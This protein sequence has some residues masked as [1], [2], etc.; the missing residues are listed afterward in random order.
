[1]VKIGY[2]SPVDPGIDRMAWSGTFYNT[3]H[4]IENAGFE[5]KWIPCAKPLFIYK[6]M[7]KATSK[8]YKIIY[9]QGSPSHSRLMAVVH[10]FFVNKK[11]IKDCDILFIPGQAE[12]VAGLNCNI[13][14]IYY[15]DATFKKMINYYWF[16]FSSRAINEGNK[17]EKI[18]IQKA[19]YN[20]RSSHWA[21]QSTIN[22]YDANKDTT[23]VFP[24]GA[25]VPIKRK[26]ASA[27]DYENNK[28]KLLFSGKDWERKGG[29][30]AVDAVEYLN[31]VGIKSEL[32]IVGINKLPKEIEQKDF[33]KLIGYIDKNNLE[34]YKK[35]LK[36]YH[37]CNA[38]ILPT[39]AECS[40]LVFSEANAF[41]MPIFSTDTG[42]VSDYVVNGENGYRLPLSAT[43]VDFGKC[44]EKN[45]RKKQFEKLSEGSQEIYNDSTS[46]QAW[47]AHFKAFM[48]EN[49]ID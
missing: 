33:L 46:W 19:T 47:S 49:Y 3:F 40:A 1:M 8:I 21:A 6:L 25:D 27:P 13:P 42:G 4:A 34:D 37:E 43:G 16:N 29:T 5:I 36:L 38:F 45:Y 48:E 11:L 20:F 26:M 2:V 35:Y 30:I 9:K 18:A 24:F 10:G 44:I 17:T 14:I 28:L 39:R 23:F 12:V 31:K 41:N 15:S 32:Y 7:T 22:D